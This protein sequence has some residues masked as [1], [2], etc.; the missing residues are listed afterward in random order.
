MISSAAV[1]LL[2]L[3]AVYLLAHRWL[4]RRRPEA[5]PDHPADED[6]AVEN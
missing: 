3:P 2:V 1:I 4:E 5:E 6:V